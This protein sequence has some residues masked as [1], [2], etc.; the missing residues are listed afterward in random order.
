MNNPSF[1]PTLIDSRTTRNLLDSLNSEISKVFAEFGNSTHSHASAG[2]TGESLI[3]KMNFGE[4]SDQVELTVEV[5]GVNDQDIDVELNGQILTISGKREIR[6]EE[7]K[8]DYHLIERE[9]GSFL[10]RINLDFT[11]DPDNISAN[12]EAGVLTV[13]IEKPE[14][15]KREKAK[16]AVRAKKDPV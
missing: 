11:P 7:D 15:N 14:E 1:F 8:K 10:R 6:N 12:V 2:E 5:P 3:A 9:S 4:S 13:L 16:I